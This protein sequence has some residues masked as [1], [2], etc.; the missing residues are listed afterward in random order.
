[1]LMLMHWWSH[2]DVPTVCRLVATGV[3]DGLGCTS[4]GGTGVGDGLGSTSSG[5][6]AEMGEV[7]PYLLERSNGF[8]MDGRGL[9]DT[10]LD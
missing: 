6:G 5:G 2:L 9:D 10:D 1:M 7:L 3:G 4:G 8:G